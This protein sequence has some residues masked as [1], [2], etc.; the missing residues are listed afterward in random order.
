MTRMNEY[1]DDINEQI[2]ACV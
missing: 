2:K 1:K